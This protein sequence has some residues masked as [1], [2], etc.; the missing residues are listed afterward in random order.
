MPAAALSTEFRTLVASGFAA[1]LPATARTMATIDPR[2]IRGVYCGMIEKLAKSNGPHVPPPAASTSSQYAPGPLIG[3]FA[4]VSGP[5]PVAASWHAG[6]PLS[7]KYGTD[8]RSAI[9][10]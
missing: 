10:G 8:G 6:A 7:S 4:I 3:W 9:T 5:V 1:A 2:S